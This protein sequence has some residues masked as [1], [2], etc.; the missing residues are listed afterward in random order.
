MSDSVRGRKEVDRCR[1]NNMSLGLA[2]VREPAFSGSRAPLP[3]TVHRADRGDIG[4]MGLIGLG[5]QG[6]RA[7][8]HKGTRASGA[9]SILRG[10]YQSWSANA[11]PV[12]DTASRMVDTL[13]GWPWLAP[14]AA[15]VLTRLTSRRT[16]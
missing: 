13:C 8:G 6:S 10:C 11:V 12:G 15:F 16:Y 9:D 2:S 7:Q 5:L 4:F 1:R 3:F 14:C